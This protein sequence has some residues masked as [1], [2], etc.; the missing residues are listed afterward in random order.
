[1]PVVTFYNEH[2]SHEV[3]GGTNAAP[4]ITPPDHVY[5][6]APVPL[7]V[8][9]DPEQRADDGDAIELTVGSG[10]NVIVFVL[11]LEQ[12]LASVPVTV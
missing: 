5:D 3:E 4:L 9:D 12:P 1:M 7:S 2:R 6:V 8:I 11:V 10:F